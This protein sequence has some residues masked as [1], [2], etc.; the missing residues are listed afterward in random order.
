[1]QV[2][3]IITDGISYPRV[4]K[5]R[6]YMTVVMPNKNAS[7]N[8]YMNKQKRKGKYYPIYARLIF[9]RLKVEFSMRILL[10]PDEWNHDKG[11]LINKNKNMKAHTKITNT[12]SEIYKILEDR[13]TRGL[14]V[15]AKIIKQIMIGKMSVDSSEGAVYMLIPFIDSQIGI[16]EKNKSEYTHETVGHYR[17]LKGHIQ[18]LMSRKGVM[19]VPIH[20]MDSA[21]VQELDEH[22]LTWVNPKLGR[23][24]NRNSANKNHSK[25]K[26][27]LFIAQRKKLID[28]NPYENFKLKRIIPHSDYLIDQEIS[29]IAAYRFDNLSLEITRDYLLFSLWSGGLRMSDLKELKTHNIFEEDG[30]YFLHLAGQEKT[31][32]SVHTPLLPGAVLIFKKYKTY[33]DETGFVLPRLSQ[34]K[35]NEYLK[36]VGDLAGVHK[37]MTHKIAR[38]SCG[39]TICSR[40]GV[41]RHITA[42]WLGHKLQSRTTDIYAQVTKEESFHWLKKL[43]EL[44]N[45]PEFIS[46]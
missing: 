22:L 39:T 18:V 4:V 33:Q 9:N 7:V 42:A 25:F 23:A 11:Q 20:T 38:H 5:T 34:Q 43:Y 45:K 27:L 46:K 3:A 44:Y 37:K 24:M 8:F 16:M 31:D 28:S 26:A 21:F 19:D 32:N 6:S 40:N 41:P 17:T 36:T 10:T 12:E 15:S 13:Q 1:M 2:K 29:K 30:H 14:P 35:L